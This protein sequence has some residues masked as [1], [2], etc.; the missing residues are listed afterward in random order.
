MDQIRPM[1]Q[2]LLADR[3]KLRVTRQTKELPVFVL[4]VAKDTSKL[5]ALAVE[6]YAGNADGTFSVGFG[7][8]GQMS[9][10]ANRV[11]LAIL[12]TA[13]S[14]PLARQVTD[15][16]DMRGNYSFTI[17]WTGEEQA[18][19]GTTPDPAFDRSLTVALEE[20][21]GLKLESTKGPVET[22]IIDHIEE[23]RPN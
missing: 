22:I 12:A 4:V 18:L 13:L 6:P 9:L 20:K 3:F 14:L 10:Q 11:T 8:D 2:S 21:T 17:R 1:L 23:P 19:L 7:G 5:K 16:T 15:N